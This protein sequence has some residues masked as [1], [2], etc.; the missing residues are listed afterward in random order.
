[1][2]VAVLL[3]AVPVGYLALDVKYHQ[4]IWIWAFINLLIT[5][6]AEEAFFRGIIQHHLMQ[7][8]TALTKY[9]VPV[10]VMVTA[11]LFGL[12]HFAGGIQYIIIATIAGIGYG[13]IY[14]KTRNLLDSIL[15]HF[16][17]NL[18]H[19]IFFTYPKAL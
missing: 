12:A 1:M 8:L 13:I 4:S 9:A 3:F 11:F 2:I 15:V 7:R 6:V 5:C 16:L 17:A 18:V 19:F 10:A 14:A